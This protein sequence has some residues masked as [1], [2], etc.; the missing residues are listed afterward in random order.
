ME[1][2]HLEL[3][4]KIVKRHLL[5][6]SN[7]DPIKYKA[8]EGLMLDI[9][10]EVPPLFNFAVLCG[11]YYSPKAR[12]I[13]DEISRNVDELLL[14]LGN[15]TDLKLLLNTIDG[16]D[17]V[18]QDVIDKL[19]ETQ[20]ALLESLEGGLDKIKHF[21]Y[22][23]SYLHKR[24]R[25]KLE[26]NSES[27]ICV[28]FESDFKQLNDGLVGHRADD[29]FDNYSLFLLNV[30]MAEID[31]GHICDQE[32][33]EN[34]VFISSKIHTLR[35]ESL[36]TEKELQR[37]TQQ[38]SNF[39]I[40][41][42][43]IRLSK[44]G[45]EKNYTNINFDGNDLHFN[46]RE[47]NN[48]DNLGPFFELGRLALNHY[49]LSKET[50]ADFFSYLNPINNNRALAFFDKYSA[51]IV[52]DISVNEVHY[53]CKYL[54]YNAILIIKGNSS[55]HFEI[56]NTLWGLI[57]I[58]DFFLSQLNISNDF[59]SFSYS[60]CV[61][62]VIN[63]YFYLSTKHSISLCN[64]FEDVVK[65]TSF[66]I[67][68]F[69]SCLSTLHKTSFPSIQLYRIIEKHIIED[70]FLKIDNLE[71]N[72]SP[73]KF[74][75]FA[76]EILTKFYAI[77]GE[78]SRVVQICK[79]RRLLPFYLTEKE[80]IIKID[81]NVEPRSKSLLVDSGYVL[82]ANYDFLLRENDSEIFT[83]KIAETKA[84][85]KIRNIQS[86]G[87]VKTI[88]KKEKDIVENV[89]RKVKEQQYGIIQIIGLYAS[90]I[91]FVLGS[92]SIF[93]RLERSYSAMLLFMFVFATCISLFVLLLKIVF[94]SENKISFSDLLPSDKGVSI[95]SIY[96][97]FLFV[98]LSFSCIGI[99]LLRDKKPPVINT[100]EMV[101]NKK[102]IIEKDSLGS[103]HYD[104]ITT[105]VIKEYYKEDIDTIGKPNSK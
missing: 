101:E 80:C 35:A 59:D 55:S 82:P 81:L 18:S 98:L 61:E 12:L 89:E 36:I 14:N 23:F 6:S 2:T 67:E 42:I 47:L 78:Y 30:K 40:L 13:I 95:Y 92:V 52:S 99:Y 3:I 11:E 15:R 41:K 1:V 49:P 64:S 75:D 7:G 8:V 45:E 87:F 16:G 44:N 38:K 68:L 39:L 60:S 21:C 58:R 22:L 91:T 62:L 43:I 86:L 96:G 83:A 73:G 20:M 63:C 50:K 28:D 9:E 33:L 79:D 88:E 25:S 72:S 54:K 53:L 32:T 93:P 57:K 19:N 100:K 74:S 94:K 77:S 90:F 76:K 46:I 24:T 31:E 17:E 97:A 103:I 105:S 71:I 5:V 26:R 4:L 51:E 102:I 34:L 69:E 48:I 10:T 56:K 104:T 37:L 66:C 85:E 70:V 27:V 84:I 65:S 29:F